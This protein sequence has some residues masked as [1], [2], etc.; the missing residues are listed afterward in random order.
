MVEANSV[1]VAIITESWLDNNIPS[2][3]VSLGSSFRIF[4]K[5]RTTSQG[6]G[7]LAYVSDRIPNKQLFELEVDDKE[8]LWLLH[9]PPRINETF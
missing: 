4:R 6:G 9:T 7:V 2:S 5:D 3:A 8:V 1:N